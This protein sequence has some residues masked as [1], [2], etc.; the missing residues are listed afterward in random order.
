MPGGRDLR[1]LFA[2]RSVAVVGASADAAKWGGDLARRLHASAGGRRLYF[3][4]RRGGALY[5][6]PVAPSLSDLPETPDLVFLAVPATAC[7]EVVDEGLR[8]GVPA[9]V[10]IFAGLGETGAEGRR[11]ERSLAQR[12]RAAGSVLLGPNCMGLAD[13][14]SGLQGVPYLD[15]PFGDIGFL[16]QSGA[17]GE[18]MAMRA[19]AHGCGFSR[20]VTLG[21]QADL[22]L[23]DLLATFV[24]H[25]PTKVVALYAE[26]LGDGRRLAAV[27]AR[28]AASGRPVVLLCPGRSPAGAR[29]A[30]SHTGSLT[31]GSEVVDAVC[32]AGGVIRVDT[33]QEL[34]EAALALRSQPPA[35]G[36]RVAVVSDGGGP[37]GIAADLLAG[38]GLDVPRFSPG[39]VA[40]V[41]A[42]LPLSAGENPLDFALSTIDP[43]AFG[44]VLPVLAGCG[45]VDAVFCVGQ[46]GY[47]S[48]RFPEFAA[49]V[50]A[51]VAGA[52]AM[53]AAAGR[54]GMP[55][56]VSTVYP[57]SAPARRLRELG[58]PVYRELASGVAALGALVAAA[59]PPAGVPALPAPAALPSGTWDYWRARAALAAAGV[60]FPPARLVTDAA[61]A[62][63]AARDLGWP[64]VLKV[65]TVLHKSEAGAVVTGLRSPAAV[66][67]AAQRLLAAH[68][69]SGLVVEAE[70]PRG[71]GVEVLVGCRHD[72]QAGP[73]VVVGLGGV[74]AEA[75][76]DTAVALAPVDGDEAV[77]LLAGLRGAALFGPF[78][79]RG[80]LDLEAA[81]RVVAAVSGFAAAH[82]GLGAVEV[83]PLLL[84]P[85]GALALDARVVPAAG[86]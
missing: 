26:G 66:R 71:D 16:S 12:V 4:N 38:A 5:G 44:A 74:Q 32:R 52:E 24:D 21:N 9:F 63:A 22:G 60:P 13:A 51:E 43:G 11:R 73:L 2:P 53:A 7:E 33:P 20:Y 78:R 75:L 37:G 49:N 40:R 10:G 62:V 50:A 80:A 54:A 77:R 8:L 45:E 42:A 1:P 36:R 67:A 47:W 3:V 81:G 86:E 46:L 25:E 83:N 48:A 56:V 85:Q 72:P 76:R 15:V 69:G 27:A 35:A 18:E 41:R 30:L 34:F 19:R 6:R 61:A 65:P 59:A 68:P 31:A 64:V 17:M 58:V 55:L 82:E 84:L 70:A 28:V 79:G 39:L 23:S 29:A 57:E 14:A